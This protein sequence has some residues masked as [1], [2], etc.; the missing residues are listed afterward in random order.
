MAMRQQEQMTP[1]P[2]RRLNGGLY[3]GEAFTSQAWAN[4]P[5]APNGNE[6]THVALDIGN[7]PPREARYQYACQ[8]RPG[9]SEPGAPGMVYDEYT[10]LSFVPCQQNQS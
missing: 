2:P 9:N 7:S 4:V 6:M 8:S 5:I 1:V 10:G 3:T